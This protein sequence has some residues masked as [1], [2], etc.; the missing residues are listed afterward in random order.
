[1]VKPNGQFAGVISKNTLLRFLDRDTPPV[2]PTDPAVIAAM[3]AQ[4]AAQTDTHNN[5][6]RTAA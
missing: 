2:P 4:A 1:M 3:A 5:E 6:N